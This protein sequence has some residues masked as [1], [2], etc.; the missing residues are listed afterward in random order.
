MGRDG[1]AKPSRSGKCGPDLRGRA[2][3]LGDQGGHAHAARAAAK[4]SGT[5][6]LA[7]LQ[8][9]L[10]GLQEAARVLGPT[11]DPYLIVKVGPG[12]APGGTHGGDPLSDPDPLA[13]PHGDRREVGVA[14]LQAAAVVDLD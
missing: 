2:D 9:V 1:S 8:N 12:G 4:T 3:A 10:P 7:A 13:G 11:V 6:P 14:G 5:S